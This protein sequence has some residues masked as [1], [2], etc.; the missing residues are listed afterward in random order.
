MGL[1]SLSL[2]VFAAVATA[3]A[4][5]GLALVWKR[6]A[7][8]LRPLRVL[9][10]LACEALLM[11]TVGLIANR[12]GDFYPSWAA[13]TM[14]GN[15]TALPALPPAAPRHPG[16][17]LSAHPAA[18]SQAEQGLGFDWA[19]GSRRAWGLD[20]PP[21]VHLPEIAVR[22]ADTEV[23]LTIVLLPPK[24]AVP[25]IPSDLNSAVV[26]LRLSAQPHIAALA[27]ELPNE[28]STQLPVLPHGWAVVGVGTAGSAAVALAGVPEVR[29]VALLPGATPL[30]PELVAQAGSEA[31]AATVLRGA[32][33][34]TALAWADRMAP[35]SLAPGYVLGGGLPAQKSTYSA[36]RRHN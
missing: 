21:M 8:R 17:W 1:M 36:Q 28:L 25:A 23:P 9:G 6:F 13:L 10:V 3:A 35:A 4:V 14:P 12:L 16:A 26:V 27:A 7:G 18:A 5:A 19:D 30:A 22:E 2:L 29:A 24:S 11:I 33:I 32:D 20:A 34:S 15:A 31:Q